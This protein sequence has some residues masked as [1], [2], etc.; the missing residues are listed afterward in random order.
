MINLLGYMPQQITQA[1]RK[2][3][4]AMLSIETFL[5]FLATLVLGSYVFTWLSG[6]ENKKSRRDLWE[7]IDRIR[8][9]DIKHV[10]ERLS[11]LEQKKE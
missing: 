10:E 7:A 3:G 8:E 6:K 9:N 2:G 5:G 11:R 4:D 1:I